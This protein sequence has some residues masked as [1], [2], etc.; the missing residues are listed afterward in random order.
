MTIVVC[1]PL[2]SRSTANRS[3]SGLPDPE[4]QPDQ[5][6]IE[7]EA[8]GVCRSDWHAWQGDGSGSASRPDRG[9]SGPRAGRRRRRRGR[10][11]R[12]FAEG[13]RVTVPF[14]L[15]DGSCQYCQRGT[16]TSAR[17]RCRW[18]PRGRAGG[19]CRGVPCP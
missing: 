17:R 16:R 14:H 13:D 18:L 4:P 8:C 3:R 9:S 5:V 1:E 15:G 10:G 19:V 11:R 6:V 7:T 12:Q 2:S